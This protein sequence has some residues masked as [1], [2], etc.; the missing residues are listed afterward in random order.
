MLTVAHASSRT[1]AGVA[2]ILLPSLFLD[3]RFFVR[4]PMAHFLASLPPWPPLPRQGLGVGTDQSTRGRRKGGDDEGDATRL[5]RGLWGIRRCC[6]PV[7]CSPPPCCCCSRAAGGWHLCRCAELAGL[8]P[9]H[10]R[11][12]EDTTHNTIEHTKHSPV[13]TSTR[14]EVPCSALQHRERAHGVGS[15]SHAD[16]TNTKPGAAD[17]ELTMSRLPLNMRL[18]AGHLLM[19][20]KAV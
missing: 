18:D 20:S 19:C 6:S 1:P 8:Q 13:L 7:A 4:V 12:E 5:E 2:A 11:D 15:G 10:T 9:S 17:Y 16:R 14:S 3:S